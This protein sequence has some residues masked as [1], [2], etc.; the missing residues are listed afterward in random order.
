MMTAA[1]VSLLLPICLGA[2]TSSVTVSINASAT[3]HTVDPEYI[4]ANF[5]WHTDAE[6]FPAWVNSSILTINL[7][8]PRILTLA[9]AFAPAHLRIGGSEQDDVWYAVDGPCPATVNASFCLTMERWDEINAFAIATGLTI[10]FGLNAMQG[11]VNLTS[12]FNSTNLD[13]FLQWTAARRNY[14]GLWGFTFGNELE[15]KAQ[16]GPYSADVLVVRSL[17]DKCGRQW[18]RGLWAG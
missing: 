1:L 5:D 15:N 4:S 17:I 3:V 2:A 10:S 14:T 12:R 16:F 7:T 8:D 11:R 6:E 9:T 13:A 18:G